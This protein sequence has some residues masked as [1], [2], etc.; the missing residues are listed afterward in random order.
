MDKLNKFSL[1]TTIIIAS[2]ILGVFFY[3]AEVNKQSS[4]E[5]QQ[6]IKLQDDKQQQEAKNALEK[7]KLKLD[8]CE[9]LST[10]V[11]KKWNNI[12]GV[13][14]DN[15]VWKECV[16]TYTNTETGEIE[17]SPLRLMKTTK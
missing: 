7:L 3:T 1:P 15:D 17:T 6:R 12:M 8:E 10:G 2:L 11:M 9:A 5:R 13:T 4:I 14:Y 16:V